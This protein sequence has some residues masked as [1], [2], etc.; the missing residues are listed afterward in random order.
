MLPDK[1]WYYVAAAALLLA[2]TYQAYLHH[3]I[4][5][6][7]LFVAMAFCFGIGERGRNT[8]MK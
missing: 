7:V 2:G 3:Y 5:M 6:A 4:P 8:W 1:F